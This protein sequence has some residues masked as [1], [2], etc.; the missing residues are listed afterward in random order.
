EAAKKEIEKLKN[1]ILPGIDDKNKG[2]KDKATLEEEAKKEAQEK[3]DAKAK[4]DELEAAIKFEYEIA[5]MVSDNKEIIGDEV[6]KILEIAKGRNYSNPIEKANE[7]RSSILSSFFSIAANVEALTAE[8]FKKQAN[9][10]LALTQ[11]ARN[12]QSGKHWNLFELAVENIKK[13]A[14]HQEFIKQS[15]GENTN[16]FQKNY[17]SNLREKTKQYFF[18][19]KNKG[20]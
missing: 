14:K 2:G 10:F 1:P 6:K 5:K 3:A 20:E 16:E 12:E 19:N 8:S 13:E 9:D 4:N 15:K 11:V 7:L 18:P 17:A